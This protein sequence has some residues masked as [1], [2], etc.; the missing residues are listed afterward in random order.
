MP[1]LS[2]SEHWSP[3]AGILNAVLQIIGMLVAAELSINKARYAADFVTLLGLWTMRPRVALGVM[4]LPSLKQSR[5]Y[6]YTRADLLVSEGIL[7]I[8]S[9]VF[10]VHFINEPAGQTACLPPFYS[11]QGVHHVHN[12]FYVTAITGFVGLGVLCRIVVYYIQHRKA[13]T[14]EGNEWYIAMATL[15][16]I[17]SFATNWIIWGCMYC[18]SEILLQRIA[19]KFTVFVRQAG[20]TYCPNNIVGTGVAWGVALLLNGIIRPLFGGADGSYSLVP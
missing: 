2:K 1:S 19:N 15:N 16:A 12:V 7:C 10:A 17:V 13:L 11:L 20:N 14:S 18:L 6:L 8:L 3:W 4:I 5:S 9:A